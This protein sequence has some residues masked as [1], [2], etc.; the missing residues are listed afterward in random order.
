MNT[1]YSPMIVVDHDGHSRLYETP[2]NPRHPYVEYPTPSKL[3]AL[4]CNYWQNPNVTHNLLSLP[5]SSAV[6]ASRLDS[7]QTA[8]SSTHA[9]L[10]SLIPVH[11]TQMNAAPSTTSSS[12]STTISAMHHHHHIHQHLYP[13]GTVTPSNDPPHWYNAVEYPSPTSSYCPYT[14]ANN[15]CYDQTQW[16]TPNS[17]MP[18]KFETPYSPTSYAESSHQLDQPSYVDSKEEPSDYADDRLNCCKIPFTPVPPKN[19]TN[20]T[21]HLSEVCLSHRH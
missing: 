20:G 5:H 16:S 15:T 9:S 1:N 4:E 3:E 12:S 7:A 14:Y 2:Y 21:V 19:P 11:V 10:E 6:C 13:T 18:M 17:T 8:L